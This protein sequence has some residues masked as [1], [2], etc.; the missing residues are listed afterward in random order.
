MIES[1]MDHIATT[2][3]KDPLAVRLANID[4]KEPDIKEHIE[5]VKK[6]AEI[7]NRKKDIEKFNKVRSLITYYK[8]KNNVL[9]IIG[10]QM[11]K[12]RIVCSADGLRFPRFWKLVR[13][14][15]DLS[16]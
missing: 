10:K 5:E 15:D 9:Y 11:E 4:P 2:L 14:S 8:T 3:G 16:R 12:E 1:I 13:D 7:D 6:W